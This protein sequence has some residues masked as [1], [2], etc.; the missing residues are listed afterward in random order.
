MHFHISITFTPIILIYH[1]VHGAYVNIL[2]N[3]PIIRKLLMFAQV[4]SVVTQTCRFKL[5]LQWLRCIMAFYLYYKNSFD[6]N[7]FLFDMESVMGL[8]IS[9]LDMG[10]PVMP[11]ITLV[12]KYSLSKSRG[13]CR[14]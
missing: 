4:S 14:F 7:W 1:P 10:F 13:I 11:S 3:A 9:L 6:D 8:Y 5:R 2:Y 12:T